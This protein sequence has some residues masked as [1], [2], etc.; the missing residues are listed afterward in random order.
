MSRRLYSLFIVALTFA[1]FVSGEYFEEKTCVDDPNIDCKKFK[2][3]CSDET[4]IPLLRDACP[5]TCDLCPT[6]MSPTTEAPCEDNNQ[7]DCAS[8][9][10]DCS[11]PKFTPLLKQFCPVTCN[12]C[13]GATTLAPET[14]NPHCY[15]NSPQCKAWAANGYCSKCFYTCAEKMKYC[16]KTCGFCTKGA[17]KDC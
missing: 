17:C 7:T 3:N 1:F 10:S 9:K 5:E 16:A 14:P 12:L 4:L 11:N 2:P 15:D 13:P 6:T 8:L